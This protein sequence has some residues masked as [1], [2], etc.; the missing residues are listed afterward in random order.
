ML[1]SNLGYAQLHQ[2]LSEGSKEVRQTE[3]AHS[4]NFC[5]PDWIKLW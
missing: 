4:L 1:E 3:I 5:M 2:M